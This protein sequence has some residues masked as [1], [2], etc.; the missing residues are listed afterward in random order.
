[1]V[2]RTA[3]NDRSSRANRFS[4][5]RSRAPAAKESLPAA[6]VPDGTRRKILDAA[7]SL[8]A[9][10]G[11]HGTSVRDLAR[12]VKLQPGA[13]YVH[14]PS[15]DHIL[16]ELSRIGHEVHHQALHAAL[17]AAGAEPEAQL[18]ALVRAH[19]TTHANHPQLAILVNEELYALPADLAAP[20]LA[21]RNQSA[22]LLIEVLKRGIAKKRFSCRNLRVTAAA[23]SAMGLRIPYWYR[24]EEGPKLGT[25]AE[26]HAQLAL[27]MLGIM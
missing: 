13:L 6:A 1:M 16:A 2:N 7:L 4:H 20:A 19:I 18:R 25:L 26:I 14:F 5:L 8:F 23:I 3:M 21:L 9:R 10:L 22:A 27:P 11:F 12:Q 24:P 15:K 17:V